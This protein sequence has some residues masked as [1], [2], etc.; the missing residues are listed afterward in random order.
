MIHPFWLES[1][2]LE[3]KNSFLD[4]YKARGQKKRL[5]PSVVVG[6]SRQDIAQQQKVGSELAFYSLNS[7]QH[8]SPPRNL[9]DGWYWGLSSD[10]LLNRSRS[11][12]EHP[13]L[14]FVDSQP[15]WPCP[16][17]CCPAAHSHHTPGESPRA[18]LGWMLTDLVSLLIWK[19]SLGDYDM[20]L[21]SCPHIRAID[22]HPLERW[23][24]PPTITQLSVRQAEH[25]PVLCFF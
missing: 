5:I 7:Q 12:H 15:L 6:I 13:P 17:C 3:S 23:G 18:W 1:S 16:A 9:S 20:L 24:K 22:P 10:M 14:K 11:E 4:E 25:S 19:S 2:K 21:S 8:F